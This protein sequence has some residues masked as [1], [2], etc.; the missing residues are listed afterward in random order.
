MK[1]STLKLLT[2][3]IGVMT[4]MEIFTGRLVSAGC[5]YVQ[6]SAIFEGIKIDNPQ[7]YEQLQDKEGTGDTD[8]LWH[9]TAHAAV[10]YVMETVGSTEGWELLDKME[11]EI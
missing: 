8:Y 4:Y 11:I 1:T 3:K 5:T 7:E 10:V 6:C 2:N 9:H